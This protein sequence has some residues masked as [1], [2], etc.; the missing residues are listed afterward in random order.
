MIWT[1][2]MNVLLTMISLDMCNASYEHSMSSVSFA[3]NNLGNQVGN[4]YGV[5]YLPPGRVYNI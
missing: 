3:S 5:I 2:G 1:L 4:N